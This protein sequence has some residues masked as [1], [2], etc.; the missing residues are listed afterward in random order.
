LGATLL[1]GPNLELVRTFRGQGP[2]DSHFLSL[3]GRLDVKTHDFEFFQTN[4]QSGFDAT[5]TSNISNVDLYS[6]VTVQRYR[7][8]AQGLWNFNNY[9]P[10]LLILGLRMGAATLLTSERPGLAS[11]LPPNYLEYLGG[12]VDLRGFSRK[13]LP[14]SGFGALTSFYTDFEVRMGRE[15][16]L[17]LEPFAFIDVGMLGSAPLTFDNPI[18]WSPGFGIRWS[19]SFGVFRTT[20]AHGFAGNAPGHYQFFLSYGEEF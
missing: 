11:R 9:D 20:L 1:I 10:P 4:P 14:K 18:Y 13:E 17:G 7:I 19:S 5:L 2:T 15:L 3:E 16:P 8:Q 6:Q 12:S